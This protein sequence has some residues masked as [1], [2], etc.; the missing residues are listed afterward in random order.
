MKKRHGA[1][2]FIVAM[3]VGLLGCYLLV[4]NRQ[5]AVTHAKAIVAKDRAQ[6]DVTT[7]QIKLKA[8]G[9]THMKV[10]VVYV[11]EGSY[12][13]A[14]AEAKAKASGSNAMYAAAQASCDKRGVD[15]IRQSQCVAAYIAARGQTASNVALPQIA[16]YT[17]NVVGP[18]WTFDNAGLAFIIAFILAVV[19]IVSVVHRVV[20]K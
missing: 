12:D 15:S 8:Y 6:A 20:T 5:N 17:Y 13:R 7:D 3:A 4:Q 19:A 9:A 1:L 18:A 2:I 14:V 11:L 16:N 10:N